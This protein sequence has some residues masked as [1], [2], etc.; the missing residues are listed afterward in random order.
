[1]WEKMESGNSPYHR[2]TNCHHMSSQI[3]IMHNKYNIISCLV[4]NKRKKKKR[5]KQQQQQQHQQKTDIKRDEQDGF[6]Q[7]PV[8]NSGARER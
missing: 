3:Y 6:H 7:K 4:Y 2:Y 8:M 5:I 1:M